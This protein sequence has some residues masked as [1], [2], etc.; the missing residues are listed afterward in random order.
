MMSTHAA[1]ALP[2]SKGDLGHDRVALAEFVAATASVEQ[3]R[4]ARHA[5]LRRH[6][7]AVYAQLTGGRSARPRLGELVDA[8]AKRFPGLAP[9]ER[10]MARE[11]SRRQVDKEGLEIDQGIFFH[12]LLAVPEVGEHLL[13]SMLT[14]S[15]RAL[16]LLEIFRL[17]GR[18]SLSSVLLERNGRVAQLTINNQRCLNAE[19]EQLV[20]DMETA[21]DLALLDDDV[22][23]GVLRGGVM[24]HPRYEGRR[25]FSAGLNLV[26][27][28]EGR[29]S[30]TGFLLR[31]EAGFVSKLMHGAL[32]DP[33]DDG[34]PR[35]TVD[36]PWCAAVDSF[37]IGG[38]MQLL[39]AVDYVISADDAF[40]SLPAAQEGI[41][42]GLGNLRLSRYAGSRLA[43]KVIL[44]GRRIRATDPE[45]SLLC[46]DVVAPGEVDQAV[47]RATRLLDCP[48][49][50]ANRR[51]LALAEEPQ[52]DLR[53]YLSE[54][55]LVQAR[56]LYA[57]DV[58]TKSGR[59]AARPSGLQPLSAEGEQ[60]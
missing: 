8:A 21:V 51:M 1:V 23:V 43:R 44:G 14:P 22:R 46:D 17:T 40:Y 53:R 20:D 42:P 32:L 11:R 9:T 12:E 39:L 34:M 4:M 13:D 50:A 58:V 56:R 52:S 16:A 19:D 31:R 35:R 47:D 25:V 41:V 37:A 48:A 57:E 55:A 3:C 60:A 18:V 27:L 54:F 30:L 2:R 15:P 45:A 49:V 33:G 24:T 7:T 59:F 5:F 36:K 38:G 28:H 29:I 6:A 26:D 10:E